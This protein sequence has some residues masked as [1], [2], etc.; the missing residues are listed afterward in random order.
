MSTKNLYTNAYSSIIDNSQKGETTLVS[1]NY[2]CVSV[3]WCIPAEEY[4]L[5]IKKNGALIHDELGKI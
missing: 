4:C 2:E 1:L 5:S 3:V